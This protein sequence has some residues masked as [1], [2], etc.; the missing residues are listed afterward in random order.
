MAEAMAWG[1]DRVIVPCDDA[2]CVH[3]DDGS[4]VACTSQW[5]GPYSELTPD[6]DADP[7]EWRIYEPNTPDPEPLSWGAV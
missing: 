7:P 2:C 3:F 4:M 6:I 5:S 1:S